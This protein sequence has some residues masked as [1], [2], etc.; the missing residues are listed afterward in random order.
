MGKVAAA[1]GKAFNCKT[2]GAAASPYAAA[3]IL[4]VNSMHQRNTFCCSKQTPPSQ[5]SI[6]PD[7]CT[8]V[9]T[10]DGQTRGAATLAGQGVVKSQTQQQ[11]S[12]GNKTPQEAPQSVDVAKK[13]ILKVPIG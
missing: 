10:R 8:T 7:C 1:Q 11:C 5:E 13:R 9:A 4:A 2:N 3:T 12:R 6:L